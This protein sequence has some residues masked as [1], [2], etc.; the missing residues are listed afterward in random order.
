MSA[1]DAS[2]SGASAPADRCSAA[3]IIGAP[4]S[5][6]T[7]LQALLGDHDQ[8]CTHAELQLFAG[9]VEPWMSSWRSQLELSEAAGAPIG[10]PG[11]MR[12]DELVDLLRGV[13]TSV[14]ERVRRAK[15]SAHLVLDKHPDNSRRIELIER[16]LPHSRFIHLIR[17]GRDVAS[18]LVAASRAWGRPWAPRDLPSAAARWRRDLL[19]AR[20]AR[21]LGGRYLEVRYEDLRHDPEG[22]L[23]GIV[24]FLSLRPWDRRGMASTIERYGLDRMKRER[25]GPGGAPLPEG[26]VR[27]GGVGGWRTEWST[28]ERY[29]V[30]RIAG[31]L[32]V[33]L[34][35]AE[36]GWWA[37]S[38]LQRIGGPAAAFLRRGLASLERRL[39]NA[40][41][42]R[43]RR[44]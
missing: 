27:S 12:E 42:G 22:V 37:E 40:V 26:F 1:L 13:V 19:T 29:L 15:P 6:T 24:E 4:R 16:V 17:D 10:L 21:A 28:A 31:P 36:P 33:E 43:R 44:A 25:R 14:F 39:T 23:D 7:W 5:G 18:S 34:G 35:Y 38:G 8:V 2:R 9:Y 41:G 30:H 32:L 11:L 3:F 20:A